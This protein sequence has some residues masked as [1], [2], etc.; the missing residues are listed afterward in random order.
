MIN[1]LQSEL[2]DY[3]NRLSKL[4]A[5]VSSYKPK[6]DEPSAQVAVTALASQPT[7]RGRPK[8]SV[9]AVDAVGSPDES[10]PRARGRKPATSKA[11][12]EAKPH[13]FEKV[14]LNK[15]V[16]KEKTRHSAATTEQGNGENTSS[17]AAHASG[18]VDMNG[19]NLIMPVFHN[20][21]HLQMCG[22]GFAPSL[23]MKS[24]DD[25]ATKS[26]TTRSILS[27]Q[28]TEM[29]T[30]SSSAFYIGG[31]G[32]EESGKNMLSI[33]SQSFYRNGSVIR[34]GGK[35]IPGWSFVNEEDASEELEVAV[36][37]SAKNE[38][39]AMGGDASSGEEDIARAKHDDGAYNIDSTVGTSPKGLSPLNNW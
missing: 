14:V 22:I 19:S 11:Q 4:E 6:V 35:L 10:H 34:E 23:E 30:K 21:A 31:T 26:K 12:S 38:D 28:A 24:D 29:N 1:H 16:D 25:K 13:V 36:L 39:D 2:A 18:N 32:S 33:G 7:K 8:R 3:K 17:D 9:A 27:Q 37:G 20:P 5:E 15:V